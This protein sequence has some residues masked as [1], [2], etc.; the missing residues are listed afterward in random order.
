MQAQEGEYR[1]LLAEKQ[2]YEKEEEDELVFS[3]ASKHAAKV[4]QRAW[5]AYR[6]RKRLAKAAKKK[7]KG[8]GKGKAK[9][10]ST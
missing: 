1:E 3:L 4:I 8:R 9:P 5:R 2:R 7:G 10:K 6:L